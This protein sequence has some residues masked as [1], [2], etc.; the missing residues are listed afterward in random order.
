MQR[1]IEAGRRWRWVRRDD[2]VVRDPRALAVVTSYRILERGDLLALAAALGL[3][4]LL[5]AISIW[6][7]SDPLRRLAYEAGLT[8]DVVTLAL[9][10]RCCWSR[11]SSRSPWRIRRWRPAPTASCWRSPCSSPPPPRRPP[12]LAAEDIG[13]G[14]VTLSAG[15]ADSDESEDPPR[16]ADL[17]L[18]LAKDAGRNRIVAGA[19][20]AAIA[21]QV[22]TPV[23]G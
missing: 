16:L 10:S 7:R 13:F 3:G 22:R 21:E 12:L 1:A 11:S 2:P 19:D 18:Y 6:G 4:M 8:E 5:Q 23:T 20:P 15:I 9:L 14:A 17:R